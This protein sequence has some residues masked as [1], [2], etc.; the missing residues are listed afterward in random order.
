MTTTEMRFTLVRDLLAQMPPEDA[1]HRAAVA[2]R[3]VITG[4][5]QP[6][7]A[8]DQSKRRAPRV[9]RKHSA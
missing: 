5:E 7:T 4:K 9:A 3:F 2:M 1:V 8:P 6:D